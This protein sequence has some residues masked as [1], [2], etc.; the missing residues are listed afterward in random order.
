MVIVKVVAAFSPLAQQPLVGQLLIIVEASRSHSDTPHSV[1][2]L[3]TRDLPHGATA[4]SVPGP[5]HYRGFTITLRHTTLGRT[6][7]D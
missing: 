2:L 5:P 4:P 6:P 1:G 7:L 3:W